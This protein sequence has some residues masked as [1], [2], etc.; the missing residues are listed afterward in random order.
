MKTTAIGFILV[1]CCATSL[2]AQEH[3]AHGAAVDNRGDKVMGFSH[4]KT[5]HHFR[6]YKDGGAIEVE[7]NSRDD[8]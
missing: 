4:E 1:L 5:T 8:S 6:L 2:P 7:A 3:A